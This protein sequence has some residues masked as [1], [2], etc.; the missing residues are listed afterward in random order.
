MH[1]AEKVEE[2]VGKTS[3]LKPRKGN[4]VVRREP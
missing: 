4:P 3:V 1:G 2:R